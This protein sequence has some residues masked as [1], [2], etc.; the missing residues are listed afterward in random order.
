MATKKELTD[1]MGSVAQALETMVSMTDA[2]FEAAWTVS[3][4]QATRNLARLLRQTAGG[5]TIQRAAFQ[6]KETS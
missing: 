3:K 6:K 5:S 2:E 1:T 4:A